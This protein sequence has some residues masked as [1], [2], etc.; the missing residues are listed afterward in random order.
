MK[1]RKKNRKIENTSTI[2]V[3]NNY[4]DAAAWSPNR[5]F[6]PILTVGRRDVTIGGRQRIIGRAR[7]LFYNSPEVRAAVKTLA[8][9][10][11][12]LKPLPRTGDEEWN[13]LALDAW[14]RRTSTPA[15]ELTRTLNFGQLQNYAEECAIVDGDCLIVLTT[16][17][18]GGGVAV[19]PAAM[20]RGGEDG[21][22]VELDAYGRAAYYI[23]QS[24]GKETRVPAANCVLYRHSP[25]PTDPRGLTDLVSAITTA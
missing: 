21:S 25:D 16:D 9:L 18:T 10:V 13:K 23:I 15:F 22:G 11:G 8:M 24:Q 14:T 4:I 5:A 7:S 19:Y 17:K 3:V 1:K 2:P 12:E 6:A 20:V